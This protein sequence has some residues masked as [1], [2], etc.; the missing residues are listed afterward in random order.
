M[1]MLMLDK[2]MSLGRDPTL[3]VHHACMCSSL[4]WQL[5][6]R[7]PGSTLSQHSLY[8]RNERANLVVTSGAQCVEVH[9]FATEPVL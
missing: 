4:I 2:L 9:I 8:H 1:D 3:A 7:T 6:S 5:R